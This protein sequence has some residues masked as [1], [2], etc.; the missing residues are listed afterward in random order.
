MLNYPKDFSSITLIDFDTCFKQ[1]FPDKKMNYQRASGAGKDAA[2][3]APE[4]VQ[5]TP[6]YDS[7]S[8]IWACGVTLYK[9]ISNT[10]PFVSSEN[11]TEEDLRRTILTCPRV[12]FPENNWSGISEETKDFIKFLLNTRAWDGPCA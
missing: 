8:D 4:V 11:D 9:M 7:K 12:K 5:G 1:G 6:C 10:L 2:Y 3:L